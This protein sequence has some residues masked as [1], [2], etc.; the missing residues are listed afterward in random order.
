[1]SAAENGVDLANNYDPSTSTELEDLNSL[2]FPPD[3]DWSTTLVLRCDPSGA[4][5]QLADVYN[6]LYSAVRR[7]EVFNLGH[8]SL[9]YAFVLSFKSTYATEG[10]VK[11]LQRT[12][13]KELTVKN[14]PCHVTRVPSSC[15]TV[16]VRWIPLEVDTSHIVNVLKQYGTLVK[17]ELIKSNMRGWFH[18]YTN[19]RKF[20]ISLNQG[21][22]VNDLPFSIEIKGLYGAV[23]VMER[24]PKCLECYYSGHSGD[25]C[26]YPGC[27]LYK[28]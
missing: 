25:F 16:L 26:K 2:N 19:E 23:H 10:F 6:G 7:N 3:I 27:I 15:V 5:Y 1:M 9:N 18:V 20:T 17:T 22:S 8:T 21:V 4:P 13:R 14:L 28:E 12:R 24:N 11:F